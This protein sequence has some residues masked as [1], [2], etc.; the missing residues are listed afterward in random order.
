MCLSCVTLLLIAAGYTIP[1]DK[2]LANDG[3]G[4][5]DVTINDKSDAPHYPHT[6]SHA[7]ASQS[8]LS[9]CSSLSA[10]L[11]RPL[12]CGA[13]HYQRTTLEL[14]PSSDAIQKKAAQMEKEKHEQ[15][16]R[17]LA[18]QA[19]DER[20]GLRV[21]NTDIEEVCHTAVVLCAQMRTGR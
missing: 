6:S 11:A 19:R 13:C 4:L 17:N 2:R 10:S 1:L 21:A 12:P 5:I 7:L 16:L 18:Q 20:A 14:N 8:S 9:R 15:S 3:T